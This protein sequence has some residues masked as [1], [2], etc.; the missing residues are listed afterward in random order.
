MTGKNVSEADQAK[1]LARQWLVNWLGGIAHSIWYDWR[2]GGGN[3]TKRE[4]MFG[5]V[6]DVYNGTAAEPFE[7]KPSYTAALTLQTLAGELD[8]V[9]RQNVSSNLT[10]P[11]VDPGAWVLHMGS[12]P[13]AAPDNAVSRTTFQYRQALAV[14]SLTGT[15]YG[16]CSAVAVHSDCGY[17]GISQSQCE[18]K[19]CCFEEPFVSG[20]QCYYRARR[21]SSIVNV[22]V[23]GPECW[24][25]RTHL[26]ADAGTLC[27][28]N[29]TLSVPATDAPSYLQPVASLGRQL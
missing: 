27:P 8:L 28:K 21:Y 18:D 20:P 7:R 11:A 2:D 13:L 14:W 15:Q 26:G 16:T 12:L 3:R 9:S 23:A 4:E 1:Y 5:T 29:G 10:A 19:G 6:R 17:R 22:P 24:H 25:M